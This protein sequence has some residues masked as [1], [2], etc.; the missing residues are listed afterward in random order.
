MNR[1][2]PYVCA[3][4]FGLLAF[5]FTFPA[6]AQSA[7]PDIKATAKPAPADTAAK[8]APETA[9]APVDLT[10]IKPKDMP[11][12]VNPDDAASMI[13]AIGKAAKNGH[14]A[15]LIG[16]VLMLLTRVFNIALRNAIPSS[17][18][19]WVA[20]GLGVATEIIFSMANKAH[21]IDVVTSGLVAG[22]VAAGS[23]SAYGKYIPTIKAK[24]S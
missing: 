20:V 7:A 8:T 14:W 19:P 22:L 13:G 24:A 6:L 3:L 23:Y 16:L 11:K 10:D 5:S 2:K 21:W 15:L 18:L 1:C 17:V 4:G 9:P 12:D